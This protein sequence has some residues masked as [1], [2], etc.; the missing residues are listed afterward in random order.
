MKKKTVLISFIII[1]FLL[2]LTACQNST[3]EEQGNNDIN[4][5]DV[6]VQASIDGLAHHYHTGDTIE[7][8]VR[9]DEINDY[10]DW[11]WYTRVDDKEWLEASDQ[12]HNVFHAVAETNGLE[13]KAILF[14]DDHQPHLQSD[15]VTVMI[16]DH[17][18][19]HHHEH[20][21]SHAH[22]ESSEAVY[23]GYFE[24]TAIED[25]T[26]LDWQGDWQSVYPYLLAGDLDPVFEKKAE[27]ADMTAEEYKEYYTT[28]YETDVERI[29][30]EG[31]TFT[32]YT[33]DT[34]MSA[35]YTYDSYEVLTYEKGNRGVRYIFKRTSGDEDMPHYI[36]FSDHAIAPQTAHHFHL[37]W[38]NDRA[39]LLEEVT[40]WPT[41]YPYRL[42]AD[43]LVH[44]MLA[45]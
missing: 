12:S 25:R 11:H 32:F 22:D 30:I 37:Y 20:D 40:N 29:M 24:D 17:D 8:V 33:Q 16:D 3:E 39:Q 4:L 21:H 28:G 36:Q 45:H 1:A 7:L 23:N 5:H 38:G 41:F 35:S 15:S 18:D 44:D 31:D 43:G 26:L 42:D 27:K 19:D 34:E 9:A 14:D 2:V 13:I 6:P 10:R